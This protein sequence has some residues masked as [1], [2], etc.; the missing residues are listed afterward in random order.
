MN[1]FC[2]AGIYVIR[3]DIIVMIKTTEKLIFN[4]INLNLQL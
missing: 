4:F 2:H 3:H 1:P